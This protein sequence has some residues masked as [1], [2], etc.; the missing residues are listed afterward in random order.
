LAVINS[1]LGLNLP[2]TTYFRLAQTLTAL[3]DRNMLK[4]GPGDDIVKFLCR[5]KKG[6]KPCRKILRALPPSQEYANLHPILVSVSN[7]F[8][9]LCLP[10]LV[11]EKFKA[12]LVYWNCC[13]LPNDFREFIF[14]F[15][16]NRL[17][18]NTRLS[19]FSEVSRWCTFCNIVGKNLGPFPDESFTHL[20][21]HCPT[22]AKFHMEIERTVLDLETDASG[23]RWLGIDNGNDFLNI[24]LLHLQYTLWNNKLRLCLP[25]A[26]KGLGEA[27]YMLEDAMRIN[28]WLKTSFSKLNC[29]LSRLWHRLCPVRW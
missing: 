22:T 28:K 19:N 13:S 16:H 27:I 5:F 26:N 2:L 17:P 6:S 3:R 25:D 18:V 20:F 10:S 12:S 8:G 7:S 21:L 14:K 9:R 24:F 11:P 23:Q 4:A 1:S 15:F 29:P